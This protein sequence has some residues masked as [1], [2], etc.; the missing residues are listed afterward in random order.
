[1]KN[2][3]YI[4]FLLL[5]ALAFCVYK[6]FV[7]FYIIAEFEELRPHLNNIPVYYKGIVVGKAGEKTHSKDY[8]HTLMRINLYKNNMLLPEN[9]TIFLKKEKRGKRER[10][11]LELIYPKKPSNIW[12]FIFSFAI[13]QLN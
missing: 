9:S 5:F 7:Q 13:K 12:P 2:F 10:D 8:K 6:F 4:F 3:L 1:M 11:F